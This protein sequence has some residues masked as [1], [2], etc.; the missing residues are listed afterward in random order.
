MEWCIQQFWENRRELFW[1]KLKSRHWKSKN[2]VRSYQLF[3]QRGVYFQVCPYFPE[4]IVESV[5]KEKGRYKEYNS[6]GF[7]A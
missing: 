3:S 4:D 6:G 5:E 2:S 1:K 7:Q